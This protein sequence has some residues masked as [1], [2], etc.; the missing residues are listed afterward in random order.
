MLFPTKQSPTVGGDCFAKE[1]LATTYESGVL[2][3]TLLE[4][5]KTMEYGPAPEAPDAVNAWW[6]EHKRKCGLFSNNEW[7][8]PKGAK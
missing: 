5:Y 8:M 7:G 4:I 6:D 1:R 3:S 2:M